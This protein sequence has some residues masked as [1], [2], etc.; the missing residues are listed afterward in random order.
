MVYWPR[1]K[2][3]LAGIV[4]LDAFARANSQLQ[5]EQVD[6]PVKISIDKNIHRIGARIPHIRYALHTTPSLDKIVNKTCG[7]Y[8]PSQD[9]CITIICVQPSLIQNELRE[10][11]NYSILPL[12]LTK[13]T[14][15]KPLTLSTFP[16]R[17]YFITFRTRHR[18][19]CRKADCEVLVSLQWQAL[20]DS[21]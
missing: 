7:N 16:V 21:R 1:L 5:C 19:G 14:P 20:G 10:Y 11:Q 8:I 13:S 2:L 3:L 6:S 18:L 9:D 12:T 15:G 17:Y 4:L